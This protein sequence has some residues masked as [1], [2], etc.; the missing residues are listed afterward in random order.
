M[1]PRKRRTK[2][3]R[4]QLESSDEVSVEQGAPSQA[5]PPPAPDPA[6][7]LAAAQQETAEQFKD[8]PPP[9]PPPPPKGESGADDDA[10]EVV[11]EIA[12]DLGELDVAADLSEE[13]I[14]DFFQLVF[15]LVAD[16]RGKHWELP[17]RS[18]QRIGRWGHRVLERHPELLA[19]LAK[20]LP[21]LVFGILLAVE[22]GQRYAED[23]RLKKA[24]QE[25]VV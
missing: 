11:E 18:A 17:D 22:I 5:P 4:F 7:E 8:V 21:E 24:P 15:A 1:A 14:A 23:R 19:W 16:K 6:A 25:V 10:G 12:A 13:E 9:P 3:H 20:N 2:P